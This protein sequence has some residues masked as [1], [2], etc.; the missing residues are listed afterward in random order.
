MNSRASFFCRN[1]W[2]FL[3]IIVRKSTLHAASLVTM[4]SDHPIASCLPK[5]ATQQLNQPFFSFKT[6]HYIAVGLVQPHLMGDYHD[7][8]LRVMLTSND[9]AY[10]RSN[11][12]AFEFIFSDRRGRDARQ[13]WHMGEER[14]SEN[15]NGNKEQRF[16]FRKVRRNGRTYTALPTSVICRTYSFVSI[17]Y[18]FL[19]LALKP[20][21]H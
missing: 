12:D 6:D 15:T 10:S 20:I 17:L 8:A 13:L 11:V 2:F 9:K 14:N 16:C 7:D 21:L 18:S 1:W 5:S 4:A 19:C 3:Q